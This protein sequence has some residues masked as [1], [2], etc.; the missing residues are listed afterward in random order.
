MGREGFGVG[1]GAVALGWEQGGFILRGSWS[2]LCSGQRWLCGVEM[3]RTRKGWPELILV[4]FGEELGGGHRVAQI[5]ILH[6]VLQVPGAWGERKNGV[7][8]G[9]ERGAAM[10]SCCSAP[11]HFLHTPGGLGDSGDSRG[12]Q[13]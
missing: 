11:N 3:S 2:P 12:P 13:L 10:C 5:K 6:E 7:R 9:L 1:V 4:V 8:A